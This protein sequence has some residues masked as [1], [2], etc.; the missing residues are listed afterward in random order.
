MTGP[1]TSGMRGWGITW[2][3]VVS[4][5]VLVCLAPLAA[6]LVQLLSSATAVTRIWT[7]FSSTTSWLLLLR[8]IRL[9][10]GATA[11]ALALGLP[12]ALFFAS[13]RCRARPL[14][15]LAHLFPLFLP[16][17][18]MALGWYHLLGPHELGR[19]RSLFAPLASEWGFVVMVGLT[20]MPAATGLTLLGLLGVDRGLED[21]ALVDVGP[22]R[23][24]TRVLLPLARPAVTL[25]GLVIFALSLSEL[26][27]ASFLRITTYQS[28]VMAQVG[29]VAFVPAEALGL[30]LPMILL[31]LA[32]LGLERR[33]I[34]R[35]S[36]ASLGTSLGGR[37]TYDLGRW[38]LPVT[39]LAWAAALAPSLPLLGLAWRSGWS[40]VQLGWNWMG[41]TL[42]NTLEA[43]FWT[44][45]LASALGLVAGWGLARGG[46]LAGLVD[47]LSFLGFLVPGMVLGVGI[48]ALWNHQA[49]QFVY[50]STLVLVL[51][52]A[53]RSMILASRAMAVA[54]SHSPVSPE[55]AALCLDGSYLRL[56]GRVVLPANA[57]WLVAGWIL[58]MVFAMRELSAVVVFYPPGGDTLPLRIFTL[59]ANGPPRAVA[60]LS[61]IHVAA[62]ALV[63]GL[64]L[65]VAA[66]TGGR[67][68]VRTGRSRGVR[69]EM[70]DSR[71]QS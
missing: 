60:G 15:L 13:I 68:R 66:W 12:L 34:G 16:P 47:A 58:G 28:L 26:G 56:L 5:V 1:A 11:L 42:V 52:L 30:L 65:A 4:L 6:L 23:T 50:G 53:S 8:S 35:R 33:A 27:V 48:V 19:G 39:I 10:L 70:S 29:G 55:E 40:G 7:V 59:E 14:L 31:G 25:A 62:T 44:A 9:A 64:G 46:R 71:R 22:W 57:R 20:Y 63:V 45:C 3:L 38:R 51:G 24:V 32:L 41:P 61:L 21:A 36:F 18:L 69:P 2:S 67:A 49:T 43:S 54:V 37:R 17:F